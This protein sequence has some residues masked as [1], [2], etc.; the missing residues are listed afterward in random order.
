MT[1]QNVYPSDPILLVDDEAQFLQS[2]SFSLKSGGFTNVVTKSDSREVPGFLDASKV[3]LV[4]LDLMMPHLTGR[5]L[6][7]AISAKHSGIPVMVI[8]AVNE[9]DSAVACMR[10]GAFD[11][12]VK[13]VDKTRLITSV[14]KALEH[15]EMSLENERLK[16]S[17]LSNGLAHPEAFEGIVT[18]TGSMT[19]LFRYIEAIAPSQQ[20][21]LVLGETGTG[22]EVIARAIHRAS[23]RAGPFVAVNVAGLDDTLFSDTLFG[24]L[25]GAFTGAQTQR[26]GLIAK[27]AEG[28]IFLD[29]IGDLSMESQ[30]KLLRLLEDRTYYPIGADTPASATARVV[31]ATNRQLD[32]VHKEG[33]FRA[34][35]Y[36]RLQT[37]TVRIPP[38]R[39]R[40]DDLVPLLEHFLQQAADELSKKKPAFPRELET[41]LSTHAFP[42]NVRELRAMV[43][44]AV[45]MHTAG[46][47][48]MDSFKAKIGR[49]QTGASEAAPSPAQRISF[50]EQLPTIKE[51]ED[52]LVAESLSRARNNQSIAAQMLGIT[53]SALNKRINKPREADKDL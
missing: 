49:P 38:L 37:H 26:E 35:L 13:P 12:L 20:P 34:D 25:K 31:V 43:F 7:D 50:G 33:K 27:A 24:H 15:R 21:V 30:V 9:V 32:I 23:R 19:S 1:N 22:K 6:L 29:E 10:A 11:Y 42:G 3:S 4:I 48:S 16:Q 18:R 44:D 28:T 47:L 45:S 40:K 14:R 41:L 36:Y 46:I 8:T 17:L 52:L 39:E 53:R 51:A 5:D 2:A